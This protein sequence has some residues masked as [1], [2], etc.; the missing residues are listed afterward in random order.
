MNELIINKQ[1]INEQS[2]CYV[3]AEIGN[4]HQGDLET[5]KLL[6]D[7]AKSAGVDAVK[8][9]RRDNKSLYTKAYYNRTYDNPVSFGDTYGKH[10]EALELSDSDF[11]ELQT[12]CNEIDITF[13]ST[14]FDFHSADYLESIGIPAY[15][16][17]SG[18][19]KNIPLLTHIAKFGKPL[20][21]STGGG[22][23]EDV[24]RMYEA[25]MP[26]NPQLCI[27]HCTAA[28][29]CPAEMLNL[30]VIETFQKEFPDVIVGLSDHYSGIISAP[31][32]YLLGA[33]V[34]EKHFTLNHT[35]K[36]TDHSFSL[37]PEG[38][39]KMVRDLERTKQSLGNGIKQAH[40]SERDPLIKMGKKLVA[41]TDLTIGH[42]IRRID[43]NLKSPGDGLPPYEMENVL[44]KLLTKDLKEDE[45]IDWSVLK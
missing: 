13:F 24:R 1:N 30:R 6:V 27:L 4:N 22:A 15:K 44:G 28:Y 17:A 25:L 14:A 41:A 34:V 2:D 38:M 16:T 26:I 37:I 33:R 10:R 35:M 8:T 12:Y 29:P 23:L 3:I 11:V 9:Q 45:N 5:A 39:R 36:G 42:E 18:D 7:A 32:A 43:I 19:L 21:V 40:E 31:L 20:I